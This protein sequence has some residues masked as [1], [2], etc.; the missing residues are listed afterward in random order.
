[1]KARTRLIDVCQFGRTAAALKGGRPE[2]QTFAPL[3][4][5][6]G[7]KLLILKFRLQKYT[8]LSAADHAGVKIQI[9][10]LPKLPFE[11]ADVNTYI[12]ISL[13]GHWPYWQDT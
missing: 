1:L 12:K 9:M 6:L 13:N 3:L 2:A 4:A 5:S 11:D 8:G 7:C 10:N